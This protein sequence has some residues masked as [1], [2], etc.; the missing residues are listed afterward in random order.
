MQIT[1]RD[2]SCTYCCVMD[3]SKGI[4]NIFE[5]DRKALAEDYGNDVKKYLVEYWNYN[6]DEIEWMI[7]D[8]IWVS[9]DQTKFSK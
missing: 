2:A 4:V 7:T 9:I 3:Y 1:F 5:V 8:N 6:L